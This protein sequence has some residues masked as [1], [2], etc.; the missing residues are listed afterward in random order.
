MKKLLTCL[1]LFISTYVFAVPGNDNCSGAVVLPAITGNYSPTSGDLYQATQSNPGGT[2]CGNKYDVWYKFTVPANSTFV[3]IAVALTSGTTTLTTANTFIEVFNSGTCTPTANIGG[4][5]DISTTRGYILTASTTY[6]VR[7]YET[8]G[9]PSA[10]AANWGFN[11][12]ITSNANCSIATDL[13]T[14][15]GDCSGT[16]GD[17]YGANQTSPTGSSCGNRW[18]VWYKF[19]MP[20]TS[21]FATITVTLTSNPSSLT[22]SNTFIELFNTNNCTVNSTS[23]GGCNDISVPRRYTGLTAGGVYYFRVNTNTNPGSNPTQWGFSVCVTSNDNCTTGTTI[24]PGSTLDES[25]LGASSSGVVDCASGT[26]DD[27]VWYSFTAVYSYATITL[28]NIGSNFASAGTR[29]QLFSG[30]CGGLSSLACSSTNIINATGLT[31]GATYRIRVYSAVVGQTGS[32]WGFRISVNPSAPVQVSSGRMNE[33]YNQQILSAPQVLA[34]PWEVTYGPDNN[35]WITESK[36]YR[37]YRMNPTTG[38]RDTVLDISQG[39]NFLTDPTFDVQAN[40]IS[41][42]PQGGLAGLALHPKFLDPVSPQN[43][44]YVSYVYSFGSNTDPN[45]IFFTNRLVRFTYTPGTGKLGSPVSLCDTLP[46]SSDHNSQRMIIAPVAGTDYL[47]YA[48]GDMGAGQF[49]NRLRP[50]KAQ[51]M[52][53]YEGKILRFNLVPDADPGP[54]L[55]DKWIPNTNPYNATLGVQ[56]AVWAMGIRNNQG[57]A[58]DP[59]LNI[60]YGSSHGPFSDDEINIIQSGKN[61][62]HPRVIGFAGDHNADGTTAGSAPNMSGGSTSSC[63]PLIGSETANAAAIGASYKDPMFSAY[64]SS[65]AFPSLNALWNSTSGANAQWP[66]EAWSGLDLY[67]STVIPGWKKSLV[68]ASLKW[69]RLVRLRLGPP[70]DTTVPTNT[71]NDTISY[72]GSVN[73]FRDLAFAPNGKDIY[74]IMDR[75]TTTSGP[76]ALNPIVPSCPGCVQKYTFLGY[77]DAAGKSTIPASLDV[78]DGTVNTCNTGTTVVIDNTNNNIWVPITGPDG[79]IMAEIYANGNNLGNVTSSFYKKAPALNSCRVK[80]GIHYLDRNIRITPQNQPSSTVKIRLYIS[81][82]EYD[83]LDRDPLSGISAITDLKILKNSDACGSAIAS[84]TTL[85]N[86]TF[87]EAHGGSG[88]MLQGNISSFSSFYFANAPIF[89]PM[90]LVNFKGSLQNNATYLDW[91]TANEI[92]TASFIV[93]RSI[94]GSNFNEI[95]TVAASGHTSGPAKY[96]YIDNDVTQQSSLVI[97]Y[98]LKMVDIDGTYKYSNIVTISL[99]DMTGAVNASPNPMT[100]AIRVTM[101]S[102]AEGRVQWK[103]IDNTGRVV[104]RNTAAVRKGNNSMVI[105]VSKL[106]AGLYYLSVTGAGIDQKIKLQKL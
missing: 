35:L 41:N 88:Y 42:N 101:Q 26:P 30:S 45:G 3:R 79:N 15:N 47:F 11:I 65:V 102:P 80:N 76:S 34:D 85:V 54:S 31:P 87:A 104:L 55:L 95:G 93:E 51:S 46:G 96:S 33:I 69:G 63:M 48:Q 53:S 24:T 2:T 40:V 44:V 60:L 22:T 39:S 64:P 84:S 21:T 106:S 10:N 50:N 91:E 29:M 27:D 67:T 61:Y 38:V 28:G 90:E 72:F 62:G 71:V 98:R 20:A 25:V 82:A 9:A 74:V 13:S 52:N 49:G 58:Y 5:Q 6:L 92:N 77:A 97:Y 19:T 56:S 83:S 78:A 73:R 32:N 43:Y 14:I 8:A 12:S 70:G 66:S 23:T 37:I 94:D 105:N 57:F 99:A 75:S 18:D 36:G 4:C 16:D 103:L 59:A 86:P 68:A 81:K 100:D 7:I 89:L 17:L 1:L